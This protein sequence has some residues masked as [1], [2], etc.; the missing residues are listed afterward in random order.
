MFIKTPTLIL[1]EPDW[2]FLINSFLKTL[3]P[4]G[5]NKVK[6]FCPVILTAVYLAV[7]FITK[8]T[9]RI[10]KEFTFF[11]YNP[12]LNYVL[13]KNLSFF[14]SLSKQQNDKIIITII[15]RKNVATGDSYIY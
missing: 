4:I 10:S 14:L 13:P 8:K 1:P 11:Q 9:F 7:Y 2:S 15:R 6:S 5:P 12:Y 3:I